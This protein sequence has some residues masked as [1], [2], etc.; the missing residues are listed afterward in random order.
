MSGL[1]RSPTRSR[2]TWVTKPLPGCSVTPSRW[3]ALLRPPR[4]RAMNIM[5]EPLRLGGTLI[6]QVVRF[7]R[8]GTI[9]E[10]PPVPDGGSSFAAATSRPEG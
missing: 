4:A 7:A 3:A 5:D 6:V 2:A 9:A 1:G 10:P 8:P